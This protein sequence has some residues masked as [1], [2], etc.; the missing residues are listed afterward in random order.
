MAIVNHNA[1]SKRHGKER[2]RIERKAAEPESGHRTNQAHRNSQHW[3]QRG[4]LTLQEDENHE[5]NENARFHE[6]AVHLIER[7]ADED[8]RVV[9]D[10]VVEVSLRELL[11]E[12]GDA[13]LT[14]EAAAMAFAP[15]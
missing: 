10:G 8:C 6:R 5:Q 13:A 14:T 9:R 11:G 2:E 12:F 3:D 1:D 15:V 4:A 7:C